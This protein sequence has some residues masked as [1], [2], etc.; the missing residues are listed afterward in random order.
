M[1]KLYATSSNFSY[2]NGKSKSNKQIFKYNDGKASYKKYKNNN[3][4]ESNTYNSEQLKK[5]MGLNYNNRYDKYNLSIIRDRYQEYKL[6]TPINRY[7][8][9][10]L[11]GGL[12]IYNSN[13][14]LQNNNNDIEPFI[15]LNNT[16]FSKNIIRLTPK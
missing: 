13:N 7:N 3:L 10:L 14:T 15:D 9:Y 8:Q 11:N 1:M 5:L 4:I 16:K 6:D 2:K 12:S